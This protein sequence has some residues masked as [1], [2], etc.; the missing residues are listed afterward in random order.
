MEYIV[1]KFVFLQHDIL[2]IITVYLLFCH[3]GLIQNIL[4]IINEGKSC[5]CD[6]V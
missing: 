6:K 4:M 1:K 5:E 3:F 2:Q